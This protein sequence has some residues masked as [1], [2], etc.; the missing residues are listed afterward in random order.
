[1]A[2]HDEM[3]MNQKPPS[4]IGVSKDPWGGERDREDREREGGNS[5]H[6]SPTQ[7]PETSPSSANN[8][9]GKERR[10]KDKD[11]R[12]VLSNAVNNEPFDVLYKKAQVRPSSF[13]NLN[14]FVLFI[15]SNCL[16]SFKFL[17][18]ERDL[19]ERDVK[20]LHAPGGK[21]KG[22]G[23]AEGEGDEGEAK[24]TSPLKTKANAR[25]IMSIEREK[26]IELLAAEDKRL[27]L[28]RKKGNFFFR[29]KYP[30]L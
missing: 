7:P 11:I 21:G 20:R 19:V 25:V 5:A 17:A 27:R 29:V 18:A 2:K 23:A 9:T 4:L 15:I 1:M 12:R 22:G 10:N 13:Y 16:A 3:I 28:L 14:T 8:K 6:T 30:K 24:K 26:D